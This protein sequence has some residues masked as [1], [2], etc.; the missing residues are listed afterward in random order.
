MCTRN[1]V[2]W[3]TLTSC[4]ILHVVP[5]NSNQNCSCSI[6]LPPANEGCEGYV[7]TGVCL[8]TGRGEGV[9]VSA[10]CP[11]GVS[12][13]PPPPWADTTL[14]ADT[15]LPSACWDTPPSA[16]WVTHPLPSACWDTPPCLVHVGIRSTS[17]RYASNGNVFLLSFVISR[18]EMCG[19]LERWGNRGNTI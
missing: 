1:N 14:W 15:P 10:S 2:R 18:D 9:W 16:S 5:S 19:V 12:T 7:F 6:F 8:S 3:P 4:R 13:T 11:R 17:G